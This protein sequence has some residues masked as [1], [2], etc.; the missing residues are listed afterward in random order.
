MRIEGPS[1]R[2]PVSGKSGVGKSDGQRPLFQ[3]G[4]TPTATA[5]RATTAMSAPTEIDAILALQAV[6]DP[7]FAKR[8]AANRGNALL[9]TLEELKADLLTGRVSEERLNRLLSLVRQSKNSGDSRLDEIIE[10][11]EL[12][13]LVELAKLGRYVS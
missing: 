8:K 2:S 13:A 10:D 6:E 11:I 4:D 7:M 9:D 1:R 5:A 3:L 12:R